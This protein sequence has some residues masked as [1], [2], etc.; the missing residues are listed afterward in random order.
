MEPL[1]LTYR[2]VILRDRIPGDLADHRRWLTTE[3][4]WLDWDAP[5]EQNDPEFVRQYLERMERRLHQPLPPVRAT[6]E[7]CF[8]DG[9]HIGM[10]NSYHIDGDPEKLALGITL[11]ESAYWGRGL[12]SQA[13][14]LWVK[15]QLENSGH[16]EVYCQ[17][18]SGNVRMVKLAE[19]C[20]FRLCQRLPGVRMVKGERYDA[21]TFVLSATPGV[22]DTGDVSV[23]R[24]F[25][26]AR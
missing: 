11:R 23:C 14:P 3:T 21:L 5:W 7:I 25:A 2:D 16:K 8:R 4:A 17:T 20:G 18:W 10:V 9:T 22:R 15:Y 1:V 26:V 19:K 24:R 6:L 13:F 12:G